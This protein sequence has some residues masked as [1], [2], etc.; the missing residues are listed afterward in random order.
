[1]SASLRCSRDSL[2]CFTR[3]KMQPAIISVGT[4]SVSRNKE[5]N[6]PETKKLLDKIS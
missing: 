5:L 3:S 2:F 1:M 6:K 4:M